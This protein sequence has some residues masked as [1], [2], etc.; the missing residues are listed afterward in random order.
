MKRKIGTLAAVGALIAALLSG[1]GCA[2]PP[3][4]GGG[5]LGEVRGGSTAPVY[6]NV[7]WNHPAWGP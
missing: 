7:P 6:K 5:E 3:A 2:G 1:G 4:K